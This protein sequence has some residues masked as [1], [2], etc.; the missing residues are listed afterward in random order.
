MGF[1]FV[2]VIKIC[3]LILN[4]IKKVIVRNKGFV[5]KLIKIYLRKLYN[6]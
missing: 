2:Y 1:E 5:V 4:V 6:I 3:V